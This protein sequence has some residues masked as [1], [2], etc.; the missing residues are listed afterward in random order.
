[1]YVY[2]LYTFIYKFGLYLSMVGTYSVRLIG[3]QRGHLV[4]RF[5]EIASGFEM[6]LIASI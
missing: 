4:N 6:H 3:I 1:M 2:K 5:L